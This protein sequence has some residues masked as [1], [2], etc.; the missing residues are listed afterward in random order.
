MNSQEQAGVL[1]CFR[2]FIDWKYVRFHRGVSN[3]VFLR[4]QD[5]WYPISG[6]HSCSHFLMGLF[7]NE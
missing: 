2:D 6:K 1:T 5:S 7:F 4:R 3:E